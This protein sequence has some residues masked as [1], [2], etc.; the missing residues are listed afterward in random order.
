M[1]VRPT[2]RRLQGDQLQA[3]RDAQPFSRLRNRTQ[4]SLPQP[5][6]KNDLAKKVALRVLAAAA[7]ATV[8]YLIG[9]PA[10]VKNAVKYVAVNL[11]PEAIKNFTP[12][13]IRNAARSFANS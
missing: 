13:F 12:E 11:V 7:A 8:G 9:N 6:P 4:V 1:S 10:P 2:Y 3:L 5:T